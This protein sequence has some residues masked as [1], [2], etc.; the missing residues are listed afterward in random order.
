M[1]CAA[2]ASTAAA[3]AGDG[4]SGMGESHGGGARATERLYSLLLAE[5]EAWCRLVK[6]PGALGRRQ[7][8]I[9]GEMA[10][11]EAA[12]ARCAWTFIDAAERERRR[13]E[14]SERPPPLRGGFI[15]EAMRCA[16]ARRRAGQC[17][18]NGTAMEK[19]E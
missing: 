16:S 8:G 18:A 10:G 3:E 12:F 1:S 17:E 6:G 9:G 15:G 2:R 7:A 11:K 13:R 19:R 14:P 5:P 4:S